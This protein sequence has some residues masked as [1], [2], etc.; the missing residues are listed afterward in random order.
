MIQII[1]W[2]PLHSSQAN[3][4]GI[5]ITFRNKPPVKA[6]PPA[7]SRAYIRK[8][9]IENRRRLAPAALFNERERGFA[10][11]RPGCGRPLHGAL[12]GIKRQ[13]GIFPT[14]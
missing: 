2:P 12:P 14:T 4:T 11:K 6:Y 1:R 3:I 13:T 10:V 7:C 9:P 8:E 5:G